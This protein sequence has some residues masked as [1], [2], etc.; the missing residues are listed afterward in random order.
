MNPVFWLLITL[1][2]V[3]LWL[4]LAPL[5]GGAGKIGVDLFSRAKNKMKIKDEESEDNS[6]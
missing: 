1:A 4:I 2:V 6:K 3:G 5:F